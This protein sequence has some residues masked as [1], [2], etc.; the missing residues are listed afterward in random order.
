MKFF[1]C[2]DYASI[3]QDGVLVDFFSINNTLP[4]GREWRYSCMALSAWCRLSRCVCEGV[5]G[6]GC[7]RE[8]F[9]G[10]LQ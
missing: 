7:A 3:I 2:L 10:L 6:Y 5:D 9:Y 8:G 1:L 4:S